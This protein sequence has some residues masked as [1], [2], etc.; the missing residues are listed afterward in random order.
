MNFAL[1]IFVII[2]FQLMAWILVHIILDDFKHFNK[3]KY[4]RFKKPISLMYIPLMYV[5]IGI[6]FASYGI[7][8]LVSKV[9]YQF[10]DIWFPVKT[11]P[12]E[13]PDKQG[14]YR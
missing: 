3:D 6:G 5:P 12:N 8:L 13:S 2:V 7:Y 9:Y 1:F 11:I 10:K 4:K 14:P